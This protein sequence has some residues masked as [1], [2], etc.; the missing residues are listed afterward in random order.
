M[1]N[2][3]IR[4]LERINLIIGKTVAWAT[5]AMVVIINYIIIQR[6]IFHQGSIAIQESVNYFHAILILFG[7]AYTYQRSRH[8]NV[9]I[10]YNYFTKKTQKAIKLVS[11]AFITIPV[12]LA[13]IYFTYDYA[14]HAW[15]IKEGSREAGGL[16]YLYLIKLALCIMPILLLIESVHQFLMIWIK[17]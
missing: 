8:V 13:L 11:I 6:A 5:L 14:L 12:S 17:K 1:L 7:I 2:K 10:L 4:L 9:D 16:P 3:L 15:Q